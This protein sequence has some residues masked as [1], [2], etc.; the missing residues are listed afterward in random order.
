MVVYVSFTVDS[1]VCT[2]DSGSVWEVFSQQ[3]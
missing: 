3:L 1:I 2:V